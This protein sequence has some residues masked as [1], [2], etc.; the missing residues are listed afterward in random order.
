[1]S[2]LVTQLV[3][4][5][6]AVVLVGEN[7][8]LREKI[9]VALKNKNVVINFVLPEELTN[10]TQELQNAY[11]VVLIF[12]N[13]R[14]TYLET[15]QQL[16]AVKTHLLVVL[17]V[18]TGI[19]SCSSDILK[20][21]VHHS[22]KQEQLIV[23]C[24]Y[25]LPN[26]SFVF[27]QDVIGNNNDI[28]MFN[29]ILNPVKNGLLIDT[30]SD[31]H[32]LGIDDF[33]N[34]VVEL[35]F[36]PNTQISTLIKGKPTN[37]TSFIKLIKKLYEAYHHTVVEVLQDKIVE[38]TPIPFS[39]VEKNVVTQTRTIATFL[40]K[41]MKAPANIPADEKPIF[42]PAPI[43]KT[44]TQPV[45]QTTPKPLA[46]PAHQ[47][48]PRLETEQNQENSRNL[49]P[50]KANQAPDLNLEIQKI[51]KDTRTEQKVERVEKIVKSTKKITS[52]SKR[53][54]K[55]FYGGLLTVGMA[56]GM[57]FLACV[58]LFSG[59]IL[60]K[61]V[62]SFLSTASETQ[63]ISQEPGISLKKTAGFV[64][65]QT[66]IYG[67]LIEL[68][69]IAQNSS[70]AD[71]VKQFELIPSILS[72]ADQASKN[73]VLNILSGKIGETTQLTE[74]LTQ[75]VSEAY[76]KLSIVQATLEQLELNEHSQKQQDLIDQ[77]GI[78]IQQIRSGLEIHQR[79]QAVLPDMVGTSK[80]RTYALLLQNN[81]ELRPTGGFIQAIAFL[82]FD[83]GSLVSNQVYSVYELDKKISGQVVPPDEIKQFLGENNW[84]LRDSNWSPDFPKTSKEIT[85]FIEK[86]L[87]ITVDGV[88]A[89]N[90]FSL[91]DLIEA[92]GPIS[93]PE[94]NEVLTQ[95]NIEERME[96]HSEVIL[97]DSPQSVDYS[98]KVLTKILEGL[99]NLKEESV[100]TLLESLNHSLETKQAMVYSSVESEQ[101]IM[102]GLGWT[103]N[104]APPSCPTRLSVVDC[105]VDTVAQ[106]EANIGI[107]KANYYLNRA[108]NHSIFVSK[109][110]AQ[111][112]RTITFDNTAQSNS[113]PKGTYKAYVKFY[114]NPTAI[115]EKALING[116]E[117]AINQVIQT[118]EDGF[119]V[120]GI[121]VDVPIQ[122]QLQ[123]QLVYSTPLS[124]NGSF[125]YVFY[126]RKQSGID[127]D[128]FTIQI[129][130]SPDIKPVLVAPSATIL[131]NTITFGAGSLDE[132]SLF[133]VQFE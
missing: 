76:E 16:S 67:K 19:S 78:K 42:M 132:A 20:P 91:A 131:G 90:I 86:S 41:N 11:K 52:K 115:L 93:L 69:I 50:D 73:L 40:V 21:W 3:A 5:D 29:Y 116:S 38:K 128:P 75:S 59:F 102:Q 66:N 7:T 109:T 89:L 64:S 14:N 30:Q 87:G 81:Q 82:N 95:R 39:V 70:L 111:H 49:N 65:A 88:I 36:L 127:S 23:D 33:V 13:I 96:F 8:I 112:T 71:M 61:Q 103:G 51:F 24:N 126:N 31:L 35:M 57:I 32:F 125:S 4:D 108:I 105:M 56:M 79:L 43:Q 63:N 114:V 119:K 98:V 80:K 85:W 58:Y 99:T 17:P 28:S 94:Y 97:I 25:Y 45:T 54:T 44:I 84:Y 106:V 48:K 37:S 1:M 113:W 100:P 26:A 62:V 122:K 53:K 120:L 60:K 123:L 12:D 121:R 22:E 124:T 77:I 130:H 110:N 55:L 118:E 9:A 68:N 34:Q 47:E 101:S 74:M 2:I 133:G 18:F 6:P 104:I 129:T 117:L 27:G 72:K 92:V 10:K 15:L 107:N 46:Q 83:N